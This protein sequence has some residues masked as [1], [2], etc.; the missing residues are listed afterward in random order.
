MVQRE[1]ELG[2]DAFAER[3]LG[4]FLGALETMGH[5]LGERLGWYAALTELGDASPPELARHTRTQPRYAR[6]WLEM[7]AA[8]GVLT[9]VVDVEDDGDPDERRFAL[10]PGHAEVLTDE[11]SLAYL[12]ALPRLVAAVGSQLPQ[13]LEAYRQGGG[14]SW[15]ARGP[16]AREAQAALNRPWFEARLGPALRGLPEVADVLSEAGARLLDVGC[17]AGWSSVALAAAFP[18][19]EV[20]GVDVDAASIALAR[21]THA[22]RSR[23]SFALADGV[24]AYG[25]TPY[26]AGL[27]FEC[28]HDM[29]DPIG[30]LSNVRRAVR[31]GGLVLVMDEAVGERFSAP[32]DEVDRLM[33]GFS[34]L[35]CLPD[36]LS[37]QPS[38][39]TGTVLRPATLERYARAA[40]FTRVEIL[41][42]EDF[43]FFR[44]Y[45]LH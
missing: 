40:G 38:V 30:V 45:R 21:R 29:P 31:P 1:H 34:T 4:A 16:D 23:V 2:A 32:A 33:Y 22:D 15:A 37:T 10:P 42:V 25:P 41:P 8:Y 11:R 13:L 3:M 12:G 9:V 28:L 7:Q 35:I 44:F 18:A 5:Y 19:C 20:T 39:G 6:E 14:V 36:G 24:A 43:S 17:G 27:F 26:D